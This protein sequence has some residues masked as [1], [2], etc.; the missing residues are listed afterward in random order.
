MPIIVHRSALRQMELAFMS[1]FLTRMYG[2][3]DPAGDDACCICLGD[4]EVWWWSSHACGHKLHERCARQLLQ[5]Q[6]TCPTCRALFTVN[7]YKATPD[8]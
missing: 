7:A 3:V 8:K 1:A 2:K 5:Y 4:D 6:T